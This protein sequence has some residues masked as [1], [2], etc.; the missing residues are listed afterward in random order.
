MFD[1]IFYYKANR[2]V[3]T[4]YKNTSVV[5][6]IKDHIILNGQEHIVEGVIY[7]YEKSVVHVFVRKSNSN[8]VTFL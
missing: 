8:D 4:G 5:P 1:I 3:I 6:N 2:S 7:D